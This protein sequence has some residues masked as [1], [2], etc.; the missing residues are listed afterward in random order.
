[1]PKQ[2]AKAKGGSSFWSSLP[3]VLTAGAL[4]LGAI[5]GLV[6]IVIPLITR[7]QPIDAPLSEFASKV[8]LERATYSIR[9]DA[10]VLQL[11]VV[12]IRARKRVLTISVAS[13]A[14]QG[15]TLSLVE[16]AP[17]SFSVGTRTYTA[18]VLGFEDRKDGQDLATLRLRKL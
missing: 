14:H 1:M 11:A 15:V 4:L 7:P 17:Q 18:E 2:T 8:V 5:T 3:G 9:D 6:Q 16:G 12:D 13:S 10:Q